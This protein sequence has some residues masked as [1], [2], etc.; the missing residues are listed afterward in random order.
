MADKP[1]RLDGFSDEQSDTILFLLEQ[2]RQELLREL[3]T[4]ADAVI[5]VERVVR[6]RRGQFLRLHPPPAGQA[7]ILPHPSTV[8]AG[9]VVSVSLEA[10]EGALRVVSAPRQNG[11]RVELATVNGGDAA[12]YTEPGQLAFTGNGKDRW[13]AASQF[14]A[15]AAAS[16]AATRASGALDATY[17][18]RSADARLPNASIAT[19]S[20]EIEVSYAAALVSWALRTASVVFAKLQDLTG[21]SVLGRAANSSGVMA[22]IT[23]TAA[24]Q[25]LRLNDAGNSLAW[26]FPLEL[27]DSGAD[28]G[29]VHTIN[30][31]DGD[32]ISASA[33]VGSGTGVLQFNW[34][35]FV[36]DINGGADATID[37]VTDLGVFNGTNT[38]AQ[39][40]GAGGFAIN[41]D[42][43]PLTGLADQADQTALANKSGGPAPPTAVA[44]TGLMASIPGA[45]TISTTSGGVAINGAGASS[46]TAATGVL[47]LTS[48]ASAVNVTGGS[49]VT[50]TAAT[51]ILGTATAGDVRL[52]APSGGVSCSAGHAEQNPATGDYL[53]NA[54]S[55]WCLHAGAT[56]AT[57]AAGGE[58]SSD[59]TIT[60]RTNGVSR[61]VFNAAGDVDWPNGLDFDVTGGV[62]IDATG[63]ITLTPGGASPAV[64]IPSGSLDLGA[65]PASAGDIR[66]SAGG[67]IMSAGGL[68]IR[69]NAITDALTLASVSGS[70]RGLLDI[71]EGALPT[72][73]SNGFMRLSARDLSPNVLYVTDDAGGQWPV[74][75]HG[76][77]SAST[78]QLS[79]SSSQLSAVGS[80]KTV[81]ANAWKAGTV[82]RFSGLARYQRGS[83]ATA[84]NLSID[85][86]T[87]GTSRASI[88]T[89]ATSIVN[90]YNGTAWVEGY[91]TCISTGAAGTFSIGIRCLHTIP[92]A[93]LALA[94]NASITTFTLDTTASNTL[95]LTM[96][97]SAAVL[98]LIGGWQAGSIMRVVD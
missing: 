6:A 41:V 86:R 25:T 59:T 94:A 82:F 85:I 24:R 84:S 88:G 46:M 71:R 97:F 69:P 73:P 79:N 81:A 90:G 63:D 9:N 66:L 50:L 91:L 93:T 42:D 5:H 60:V 8:P 51:N 33:T 21:L 57:T 26:G 67:V 78:T 65:A 29:D 12:T 34:Q 87:N 75:V 1:S 17:H 13:Q 14:A 47:N 20:T 74:N 54:T 7:L 83:T 18:L 22:A 53:C 76:Y 64:Q 70:S 98:N 96:N 62:T 3:E 52:S 58:L 36:L 55:G 89:V 72:A 35:G 28:Q 77:G 38:T 40:N 10:P 11:A 4:D 56:P 32:A 23:A 15:E 95:D 39:G 61:A 44:L 37:A 31:I 43:F 48:T 16:V 30:A 92:S 80:A 2:Q 49:Q 45:T 68:E 27:Q 19:T